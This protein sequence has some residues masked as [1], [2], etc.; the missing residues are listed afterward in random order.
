MVSYKK[1]VKI[2]KEIRKNVQSKQ[3]L[4]RSTKWSYYIAKAIL[5]PNKDVTKITNLTKAFNPQQSKISRTV[6]KKDYMVLI[7]QYVEFVELNHRLPNYIIY[8]AKKINPR[9]LT[10]GF[11]KILRYQNKYGKLPDSVNIS[12]KVFKKP[13]SNNEVYNAFVKKFGKVKT[14]DG[15]LQIISDKFDYEFYYDDK[16]SNL[17]VI[18]D[19]A[20]NCTD[21]TQ[22][23]T[24]VGEAL[25]YKVKCIHVQCRTSGTGHVFL[26]LKHDKYTDG[27]WITRDPS[28]VCN[29]ND[30]TNIWCSNGYVLAENPNWWLENRNR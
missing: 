9:V 23:L 14:I 29:G 16:K 25:D 1:I 19:Q 28:A 13:V 4:C 24:N 18:K 12:Y 5:N 22:M 11:A 21:L 15:A 2:A 30:I 7:K 6:S 26:K 20:G 17:Q 10:Y 27:E 8:D 3:K